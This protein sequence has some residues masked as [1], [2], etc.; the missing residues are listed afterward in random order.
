LNI[1]LKE[2]KEQLE[3]KKQKESIVDFGEK[4]GGAKKDIIRKYLNKINLNGLTLSTIFPKP[5][6]KELLASGMSNKEVSAIKVAYEFAQ[7]EKKNTRRTKDT[8]IGAI[9][10]CASYAKTVLAENLNIEFNNEGWVFTDHGK[11]LIQLRTSAFE[12]VA[13]EL[14]SDFLSLDLSRFEISELT[15]ENIKG[16]VKKPEGNFKVRYYVNQSQFF[17]TLDEALN[18]FVDQVRKNTTANTVVYKRKLNIYYRRNGEGSYIGYQ[19]SGK[20]VIILRDGFK[21]STEAFEYKKENEADL[22]TMLERIMA[23]QKEANKKQVTRLKYYNETTRDRVG[24][25]WR[26][27]KDVPVGQ[28]ADTFGFKAVE[29]GNW[30]TQAERQVFLNNVYDS[31]MDLTEILNVPAKALSLNGELSISF[32]SRGSGGALAHYEPERKVINLTKNRGIGSLAHEFFHGLDNYFAGFKSSMKGMK[33]SVA[34]ESMPETRQEL[35]DQFRKLYDSFGSGFKSRSRSLDDTKNKNYFGLPHE[36]AARAFENYI[37]NKLSA[38]GQVN[39]FLVNYVSNEDWNGIASQYPYPIGEE[40]KSIGEVFDNLFGT[41]E[42][43]E[44]GDNVPMFRIIGEKGAASIDR[45]EEVT[46]R[47]D[48]LA[49]AREMET[50]GKDAKTISL[51]TGWEKGVDGK[52]RYEVPDNI[53]PK[54]Y[55]DKAKFAQAKAAYEKIRELNEAKDYDTDREDLIDTLEEFYKSIG[56]PYYTGEQNLHRMLRTALLE[57]K[58]ELL[59]EPAISHNIEF[60]QKKRVDGEALLEDVIDNEQMYAEYPFLRYVGIS[61]RNIDSKGSY[62]PGSETIVISDK[63]K[64]YDEEVKSTMLHEIQ[65]A[66]QYFEGFAKGGNL[67]S[68]VAELYDRINKQLNDLARE[69]NNLTVPGNYGKFSDPK[70]YEL[71]EKYDAL[72]QEKLNANPY[73]YYK[74]LSGEVESRNVQTR[75]NM[76]PEERRNTLLQETEDVSREDQLVLMDGLG[77]SNLEE[78][79]KGSNVNITPTASTD[80]KSRPNVVNALTKISDELGEPVYIINSSEIP[81]KVSELKKQIKDG[82][83][84]PAFF[85]NGKIYL[86]SDQVTS[87]SDALKSYLHE[88]IVH[89]GLREV[90]AGADKASIIGKQY[91]KFNDLMVDVFGSMSRSQKIAIASYYVPNLYN[92]NGKIMRN[93]TPAEKALI[94]EEFLAHVSENQE[95]Y[96][97]PTLSK[98]QQFINRL[99]QI[100]RKAF[101]LTSNQFSQNDLLDIV[102]EQRARMTDKAEGKTEDVSRFRILGDPRSMLQL[103]QFWRILALK[104]SDRKPLQCQYRPTCY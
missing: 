9:R 42:T 31:L 97:E 37:L 50:S 35:K 49:I 65:H 103:W 95:I 10:F 8:Q 58:P 89:K 70:G 23:E 21:N 43:K 61:F 93:P 77:V 88:L 87:V 85:Y 20:E 33:S 2:A 86:L 94:G 59:P 15:P 99:L 69:M 91:G 28:F 57:N 75:M 5:D 26:K 19:P 60:W 83:R 29:F 7:A 44:E 22:Q 71:K 54:R 73:D 24:N 27:G 16:Y 39:D 48:N 6:I 92:Q 14:G 62:S 96:D 52:W 55:V 72:M 80:L 100:I 34:G 78:P 30:A 11:Q 47:L 82:N 36:M 45:E 1:V 12:K 13:E 81:E 63:L 90:F 101:R 98:W 104:W 66:I 25:D 84:V 51:A 32:G 53:K 3:S 18:E 102:R 41:I 38:N 76:T 17:Q 68:G 64:G 79:T 67:Q 4:L 56:V 46:T 40:S 74:R